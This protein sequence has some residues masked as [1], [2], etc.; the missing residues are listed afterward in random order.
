MFNR[1]TFSSI[2]TCLSACR[3]LW[4]KAKL[5]LLPFTILA[6]RISDQNPRK[7][8]SLTFEKLRLT[9][10]KAMFL[11]IFIKFRII[12]SLT[13]GSD[14]Q[15]EEWCDNIIDLETLER[16]LLYYTF[17]GFKDLHIKASFGKEAGIQCT[18]L[19]GWGGIRSVLWK[20]SQ[21]HCAFPLYYTV[22]TL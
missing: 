21:N 17:S 8:F 9:V 10:D 12:V 5:M 4:D 15:R 16:S 11:F 13:W 22:L 18:Y 20:S 2:P 3:P 14:P 19:R 1:H 7:C 6:C